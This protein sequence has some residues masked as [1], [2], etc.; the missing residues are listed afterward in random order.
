MNELIE[1]ANSLAHLMNILN[2][3]MP[4][5]KWHPDNAALDQRFS[6][7]CEKLDAL[8][9]SGGWRDLVLCPEG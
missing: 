9:P 4:D 3:K 6:A 2:A 7:L 5:G 8:D 1:Q